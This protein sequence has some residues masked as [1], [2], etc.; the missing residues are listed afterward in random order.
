MDG[1][2]YHHYAQ[3]LEY[4]HKYTGREYHY[5]DTVGTFLKKID[6]A[7]HY[8]GIILDTHVVDLHDREEVGRKEKNQRGD[9]KCPG[10]GHAVCFSK[11]D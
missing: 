6:N 11:V 2:Q 10:V 1:Q 4:R 8:G 5:G 3:N 9:Y 7:V